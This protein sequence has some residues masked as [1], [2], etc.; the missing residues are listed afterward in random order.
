[1][2]FDEM[3]NT[4]TEIIEINKASCTYD[5]FYKYWRN[6][7]FERIMR[8][9]VWEG[10]GEVPQKEIEFRLLTTGHCGISKLPNDKVLTAFFGSFYGVG[11]YLDEKPMYT[12]R[13]PIYSGKRT[14]GKDVAVIDNNSCRNRAYDMVHHYAVLLAHTEVS[15]INVLINMRDG[16]GIPIVQTEKQKNSVQAY[17]NSR[18]NGK[19]G[20][21]TDVGMLGI[22]YAATGAAS[23]IASTIIDLQTTRDR[24][25]KNFYSDIGVK[26]A[27][28]KTSNSIK[29]E[30]EADTSLL[31]LNI[32]DMISSRQLGC[33]K[34]NELYGTNWSVK[35]AEE[36]VYNDE[37]EEEENENDKRINEK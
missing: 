28:E 5:Y 37:K 16:N 35:V 11:K 20:I 26:S 30:V 27:F 3:F 10:T 8:L 33:E 36:I 12:I 21:I 9:F 23:S 22:E 24:L 19:N 32:K 29:E 13:C 1:M 25:L 2:L 14:I 31:L 4:T 17:I 34:V 7:L 18:F 6:N 15:Y